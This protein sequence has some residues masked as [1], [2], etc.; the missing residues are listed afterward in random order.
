MAVCAV[1][2]LL[3]VLAAH[4][5]CKDDA[6]RLS[7]VTIISYLRST[8]PMSE[9]NLHMLSLFA[10]GWKQ[11]HVNKDMIK[12]MIVQLTALVQKCAL[13]P[14]YDARQPHKRCPYSHQIACILIGLEGQAG[15][16]DALPELPK[17]QDA[18]AEY[19]AARPR[20]TLT[21]AQRAVIFNRLVLRK[22]TLVC[23]HLHQFFTSLV[24]LLGLS[25]KAAYLCCC[26]HPLLTRCTRVFAQK[27]LAYVCAWFPGNGIVLQGCTCASCLYILGVSIRLTSFSLIAFNQCAQSSRSSPLLSLS[28]TSVASPLMHHQ[29][30]CPCIHHACVTGSLLQGARTEEAARS[31]AA[32]WTS[33]D[34]H[35]ITSKTKAGWTNQVDLV[36]SSYQLMS[37][38]FPSHEQCASASDMLQQNLFS[39]LEE[40]V[41]RNEQ[42]TT[43]L[44]G[45]AASNAEVSL[46]LALPLHSLPP[47][48]NALT[49]KSPTNLLEAPACAMRGARGE[50]RAA[51]VGS[52]GEAFVDGEFSCLRVPKSSPD[53]EQ[54]DVDGLMVF[55]ESR[56]SSLPST[57]HTGLQ[58]LGTPH[59]VSIHHNAA[60]RGALLAWFLP[61]L[62]ELIEHES[63]NCFLLMKRKEGIKQTKSWPSH[64]RPLAAAALAAA[65]CRSDSGRVWFGVEPGAGVECVLPLVG[66]GAGSKVQDG[67]HP[68]VVHFCKSLLA[69]AEW[70]LLSSN[71]P[72]DKEWYQFKNREL[73]GGLSHA[74]RLKLWRS[75]RKMQWDRHTLDQ[76]EF[77]WL[78]MLVS[79]CTSIGLDTSRIVAKM[80]GAFP[81]R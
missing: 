79:T 27:L 77:R 21:S 57:G 60:R 41:Q 71:R 7:C 55:G 48:L 76:W 46:L 73:S 67:A 5:A 72:C 59:E 11:V 68:L 10:E 28:S 6:A 39:L 17:L 75:V 43:R 1:Q 2:E 4:G 29:V 32:V 50:N 44:H 26:V 3:L 49:G 24:S 30:Y 54:D 74:D 42:T 51:A 22:G 69:S 38:A 16:L 40:F 66:S 35:V 14:D 81:G 64:I 78:V 37:S 56:S 9:M 52:S 20:A 63:S 53:S 58:G 34:I 45:R 25:S 15:M 18:V 47:P 61:R 36:S 65:L 8:V 23:F 31:L 13:K 62:A 33:P 70:Q 80:H 19:I 12:N